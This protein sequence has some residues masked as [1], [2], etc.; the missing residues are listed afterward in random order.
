MSNKQKQTT[1]GINNL[2]VVY[3]RY[4]SHC[5]GEQSIEG[6][7]SNRSFDG[8]AAAL[9]LLPETFFDFG[10]KVLLVEFSDG[11]HNAV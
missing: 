8:C 2:A 7:L 3:A 6:Q 10:C 1:D 11:T 9:Y 4:S 5:Q